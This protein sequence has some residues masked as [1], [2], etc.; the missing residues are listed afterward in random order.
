MLLMMARLGLRGQE[1]IAVRL[2]DI[3]WRAGRLVVRGKAGQLDRMP[4]PVD[5]G[6]TAVA[7]IRNGRQGSSR[8]L[9]V[10]VRPP[11]R[12]FTSS[13]VVRRALLQAYERAG[14]TPPRGQARTHALRHSLAMDLLGR[15]ASLEEIGDVLRHRSRQS[16]AVY[17]HYDIDAL[18]PLARSWPVPGAVR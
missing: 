4:L 15:G 6:E 14:L 5:V 2:D 3:D 17:A 9:F 18:R 8:H 12:P 10:S 11:Y 1:A 13:P 7:W 16:T